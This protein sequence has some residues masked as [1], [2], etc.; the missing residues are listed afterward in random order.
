MK[1]MY[2]M[3]ARTLQDYQG[4]VH[5]MLRQLISP[6]FFVFVFN[7]NLNLHKAGRPSPMELVI[8]AIPSIPDPMPLSAM[9][10]QEN[11]GAASSQVYLGTCAKWAEDVKGTAGST[12]GEHI[13]GTTSLVGAMAG[14][15][16]RLSCPDPDPSSRMVIRAL[17][18]CNR[19]STGTA[20]CI[21]EP[22]PLN[23][24][25][26]YAGAHRVPPPPEALGFVGKA[27]ACPVQIFFFFW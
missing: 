26:V 3:R 15:G 10:Q 27:A 21:P 18:S 7:V 17:R 24:P 13:K 20:S 2:M 12:T 5:S 11:T 14:P 25:P 22:T 16:T 19:R 23:I 8:I 1:F 4:H 6:G 9:H